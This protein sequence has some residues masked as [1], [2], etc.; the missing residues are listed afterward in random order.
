M[1]L[2]AAVYKPG[3]FVAGRD[4]ILPS[5]LYYYKYA[6]VTLTVG[7]E[8]SVTACRLLCTTHCMGHQLKLINP[9][10]I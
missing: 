10:M 7:F 2:H 9:K 6:A 3:Q 5:A 1:L 4:K 8:L